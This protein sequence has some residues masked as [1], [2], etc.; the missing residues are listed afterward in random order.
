MISATISPCA[1][2]RCASIGSP[3]TSP[4]AQTLRIEVRHWSSM[5]MNAPLIVEVESLEAR[6]LRVSG[7]RPTVTRILSAGICALL[8]VRRLDQQRSPPSGEALRLGAG[9]HLD[10]ERRQPP[11]DRP[12]QLGV[13][14]RQDRGSASTT[15]T[16][17]PILAKAVPSSSP[18]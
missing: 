16:L 15:V 7:L 17:A 14:L 2:A 6:S 1:M 11:G 5:R 3:V 13:V 8:A 4:I 18:I 12:R 9:Q 10:A